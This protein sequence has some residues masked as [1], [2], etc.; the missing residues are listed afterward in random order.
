MQNNNNNNNANN[1]NNANSYFN[2][3]GDNFTIDTGTPRHVYGHAVSGAVAVGV[4]S[5]ISNAKKVKEEN[6]S[7]K[8]AVRNTL[9]ASFVGGIATAT[10]ISVSNNLG[11][12]KKSIFQT[13]GSL[14]L[15][16]G[17]V[18]A[19]EKA[20]KPQEDKVLAPVKEK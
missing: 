6:L 17:A 7:K 16:A 8:D 20:S 13:L 10:A 3:S 19:I 1:A 18:Y 9:K 5:G 11:D 12:P 15:G 4:V 2:I 14:A